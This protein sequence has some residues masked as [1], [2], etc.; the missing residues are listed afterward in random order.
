MSGNR[1]T[2]DGSTDP[3][4][5]AGSSDGVHL[6]LAGD[7]G[8]GTIMVN[9]EVNGVVYP[10]LDD[11]AEITFTAA[12]DVRLNVASGDI[13]IL[14]MAGS[15]APTVDYSLAGAMLVR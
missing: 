10:L 13:L 4:Y 8:G 3:Q 6:A 1:I 2:A 9:Q 11:G 15:T 5:V 7:F 12:A 14:T